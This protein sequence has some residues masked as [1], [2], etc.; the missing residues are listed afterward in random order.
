MGYVGV[1]G[2]MTKLARPF[3]EQPR[4]L[5]PARREPRI[6]LPRSPGGRGSAELPGRCCL[7]MGRHARGWGVRGQERTRRRR[8]RQSAVRG[9]YV[10]C[11]D[12]PSRRV[13]QRRSNESDGVGHQPGV[14]ANGHRG[15]PGGRGRWPRS[16]DRTARP[17][18]A[19]LA[20]PAISSPSSP[21]AECS[22]HQIDAASS[23]DGAETRH[24]CTSEV[25]GSGQTLA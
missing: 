6:L 20:G 9:E 3:A 17:I 22:P 5:Q 19:S 14:G 4:G 13:D 18:S 24:W 7:S 11:S 12:R 16:L 25:G 1:W 10:D 21:S 2:S 8:L 15:D 23:G